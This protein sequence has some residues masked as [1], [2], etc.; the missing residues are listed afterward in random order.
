MQTVKSAW[1]L[2]FHLVDNSGVVTNVLRFYPYY[3]EETFLFTQ[4][5]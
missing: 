1:I 5:S 3:F 4:V 2:S